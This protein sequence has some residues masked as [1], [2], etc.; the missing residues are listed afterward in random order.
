M[1]T[2]RGHGTS[3]SGQLDTERPQ[4]T[5]LR[6]NHLRAVM[7][8]RFAEA[9]AIF[10]MIPGRKVMPRLRC[11]GFQGTLYV[12]WKPNW[13]EWAVTWV[14]F[15]GMKGPWCATVGGRAVLVGHDEW[16]TLSPKAAEAEIAMLR[17][18][19]LIS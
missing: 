14:G 11:Q 10:A 18:A 6:A 4:A 9:R 15:E 17:S 2:D 12:F 1:A 13:I 5:E 8:E 7:G 3:R 19:G 16:V